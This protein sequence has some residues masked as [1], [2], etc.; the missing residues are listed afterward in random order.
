MLSCF[1][2]A[3][4][5]SV[6]THPGGVP[7]RPATDLEV[8]G[9]GSLFWTKPGTRRQQ[10]TEIT[11][12]LRKELK[13]K[14]VTLAHD[15]ECCLEALRRYFGYSNEK[16]AESDAIDPGLIAAKHVVWPKYPVRIAPPDGV[17]EWTIDGHFHFDRLAAIDRKKLNETA[18]RHEV[19]PEALGDPKWS[20]FDWV[21]DAGPDATGSRIRLVYPTHFEMVSPLPGDS[22]CRSDLVPHWVLA[23]MVDPQLGRRRTQMFVRGMHVQDVE[24]LKPLIQCARGVSSWTWIDFRGLAGPPLTADRKSAMVPERRSEWEAAVRGVFERWLEAVCGLLRKNPAPTPSFLLFGISGRE[25][26]AECVR[27]EVDSGA[28]IPG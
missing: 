8:S 2:I 27:P 5:I 22:P 28:L 23:S 20:V 13:G 26:I 16:L 11:L 10:G 1:M 19:S 17:E 15:Q 21:D 3:D 4:R 6:R 12:W 7:N 18:S 9:P 25:R 24:I 14:P